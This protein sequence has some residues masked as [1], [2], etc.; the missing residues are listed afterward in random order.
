LIIGF[1][2]EFILSGDSSVTEFTL[3][4]MR[5]FAALRMT[6]KA[7]GLLQNNINEGLRMTNKIKE[8]PNILELM[9]LT[10]KLA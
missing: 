1:F 3:S 10:F 5:F 4:R 8:H 7:K 6:E 2:A 9:P